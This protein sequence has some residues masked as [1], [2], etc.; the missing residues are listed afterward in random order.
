M[1]DLIVTGGSLVDGTGAPALL[2]DI[3]ITGNKIAEIG[4]LK[5]AS[6]ARRVDATGKIVCPGFIDTHTH[7]EISVLANPDAPAK[8][9]QGVTTEVVGNCGFSAF[10]LSDETRK[11]ARDFSHPV[12]GHP[13][14][15][16]DWLDLGGYFERLERQGCAVNVATLVGQGTL[17]NA[18]LG[19]DKRA[20]DPEELARMQSLLERGMEQGAFGLS[21]GLSYAPGMFADTEEIIAL[22]RVVSRKSGLYATHLRN[23]SDRLEEAVEEALEIGTRADVPVLISHHKA[24]GERNWG[25][26]KRTLA[27]LD[28]AQAAGQRTWSDVYPYLSGMSTMLPVLP[29]W[30]LEGGVDEMLERLRDG[31]ARKQ[32]RLDF[33]TGLPGWENKATVL[34][35]DNVVISSV[36]TEKNKD[37]AGLSVRAA[38]QRR[39][40]DALEL[41][42][43]LLIEEGGVVGRRSI[44]C[45]EEDVLA[46]LT[47]ARTMIGSDG[48]DVENPHPRQYGC[49]ARVLGEYVR[50]KHALALET[51]I[52][53]M[54]GLSADAFG[55]SNLGLLK[56]GKRADVVVFD[57]AAIRDE[58]TYADPSRHPKGID[59]V[60]VGGKAAV[61]E[62]K[63]TGV[64]NGEILR[65]R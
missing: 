5:S 49:F 20:P 53:K 51:A 61:A 15:E 25:K 42:F 27:M 35:W 3:A 60:F 24:A 17:R 54:T 13:E 43:D 31:E 38:A 9:R 57:A 28:R 19:F 64:R 52:H 50:E 8:I 21:T 30:V 10:P 6:A 44:Q 16:W 12:F 18:V 65:H 14:V 11:M 33:D 41:L 29:P 22:C 47:H 2:A 7:S 40:K 62:G 26:V 59:W 55:L 56:P 58:G 48:L 37:L 46:M 1:Y 45:C 32:I 63:S 4:D 23:Q 34:G 36:V 39:G